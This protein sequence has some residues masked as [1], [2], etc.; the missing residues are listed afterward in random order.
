MTI[1]TLSLSQEQ[2]YQQTTAQNQKV[3]LVAHEKNAH[4]QQPSTT[5]SSVL[6]NNL[7]SMQTMSVQ[8]ELEQL[9]YEKPKEVRLQLMV[10]VLERFLGRT[11]D[12]KGVNISGENQKAE[13]GSLNEN[14]PI[15]NIFSP[16]TDELIN[17]EGQTFQQGDRVSV[18]QWH[19]H[20]QNLNY[21]MQGIFEF[22]DQEVSLNYNFS[23]SS[24]R[25]SYS[26]V[27]MSVEALKDPIIVQF[28][29]QGLGEIN[30]QRIFDINQ[31]SRLDSLPVF[32]GDVGYLVHDTND[33]MIADNG[34]ELF[35]PKTG[36]GF[37]ELAQLDSNKNGFIDAGDEQFEKLYLWQPSSEENQE[38]QW[39]SLKEANIKAISLSKIDT[40]FDFYDQ[41]GEVQARLRQSSFAI[42]EDGAG[43]GVH[44]VDVRI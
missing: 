4:P 44:Q 41:N 28:G 11:I 1:S 40:P 6:S 36:Q 18:E 29:S 37:T 32:S 21:Q 33:N 24:E 17:I 38:E 39:L 14:A 26:K 35:G 42:S 16:R 7:S 20:E 5:P 27:E 30:G 15:E 8:S 9:T 19:T 10:L 43:R 13:N 2:S 25:Q 22:D 3:T 31:D 23:L 34:S 12:I